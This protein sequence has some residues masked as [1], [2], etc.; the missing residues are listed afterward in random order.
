M[1][2]WY[3]RRKQRKKEK[4]EQE[5]ALE[6]PSLRIM[7][8]IMTFISM[9]LGLSFLPLFPQ[10]LPIITAFL[11]AFATFKRHTRAGMSIGSLLIGVG[12]IYHLSRMNIIS[13]LNAS[14][15][16][17]AVIILVLLFL[18]VS[19]P[20]RF[21][22]YEDVIAIDFGIIAAMLLFFNEIYYFAIPSIFIA[23]ILVEKKKLTLTVAYYALISAPLQMMQYM[24]YVLTLSN[25]NWWEDPSVTPFLYVPLTEI[26]ADMQKSMTQIRLLEAHKV[27]ETITGQLTFTPE[28]HM[29]QTMQAVLT[30]YV[31]SLPGIVLF[32]V[33]VIGLATAT[34]LIAHLL[35]TKMNIMQAEIILPTFTVASA[36]VLFFLFLIG[37]QNLLAFKAEID[38]SMM[39][40][41]TLATSMF[42]MLASLTNYMPKEMKKIEMRS[43]IIIEKAKDISRGRL[44]VL[45]QL[46]NEV[47]SNIPVDISST[48]GKMLII[49][50]RLNDIISNTSSRLYDLSELNKE[51]NEL[52]KNIGNEID[53]LTAELDASLT[54]YQMLVNSEYSK[55][56]RK[57]KSIGIES[58]HTIRANFQE[59]L[60]LEM[61]IDLIKKILGEGRLLAS[62]IIQVVEQ[63]YD[64]IRSLYNPKLPE[65][66]LIVTFAKQKLNEKTVPWMVI[67]ALF[68]SLN[69]WEKQY[70]AEISKSVAYLQNSL[71][72]IANL[73]IQSERLLP[74][75]GDNFSKLME[76]VKRAKEIKISI[77]KKPL[78]V[79]NIIIIRNILQSS[80]SIAREV[81]SIL[82]E[83]LK[84]KEES[85]ESLL[86]KKDH[87]WEKNVTLSER[88]TSDMEIILNS[89]KYELNRVIENLPKSLSYFDDCLETIARYNEKRE[90]LLNYPIAEMAIEDILRQKKHVSAEDLPFEP[91]HA[92]EYLTLFYGHKF[93]E[94][95]FDKANSLL[96]KRA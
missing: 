47:K 94:F 15:E 37:L 35:V 20:F 10:P 80:L 41:S 36:T 31:D 51:F 30:R 38:I 62:E 91:K 66:S 40:I 44:S 24:K 3:R 42:T 88:I 11:I 95:S 73:S 71:D 27:V 56:V 25:M 72:S 22:R 60:P 89:S 84:S 77:E 53:K 18:F 67:D 4:E 81:L 63:I 52:D 57:L 69:S 86:I 7:A 21:H 70:S 9:L 46:L 8:F 48:E 64:I 26:F 68:T 92:Q 19:L 2:T 34:G 5:R 39:A 79:M 78:N 54:E 17:R 74:V 29:M 28:A 75:L 93:P 45:E 61:R 32:L 82:S 87:L 23:A 12:L 83:E 90:L 1:R 50:D 96:I 6:H 49:K 16:I 33:I 58:K 59:E 13:Q 43:K 85:I 55:L 14:Y 76:Y 65:E